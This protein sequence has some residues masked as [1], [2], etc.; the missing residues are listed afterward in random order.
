P[1]TTV[2]HWGG[3]A[4]EVEGRLVANAK[5]DGFL[6]VL[7]LPQRTRQPLE[8]ALHF[9][10]NALAERALLEAHGWRLRDAHAVAATPWDYQAY[11]ARSRGEFSCAKPVYAILASGWVSDPTPGYLASATPAVVQDTAERTVPPRARDPPR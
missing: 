2:T 11:V 9:D 5:R 1:F 6:G 7:D 10:S 3:H 8:L 4:I